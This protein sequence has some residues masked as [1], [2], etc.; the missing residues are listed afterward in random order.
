MIAEG[1]QA[2]RDGALALSPA[3]GVGED[4]G[5]S[6]AG[7]SSDDGAGL[8]EELA[9]REGSGREE[10][11]ALG[12]GDGGD[13]HYPGPLSPRTVWVL[14]VRVRRAPEMEPER[15][16]L[17]LLTSPKPLLEVVLL[18]VTAVT[19]AAG[20]AMALMRVSRSAGVTALSVS[21]LLEVLASSTTP[22]WVG[23]ATGS[24]PG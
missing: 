9:G 16:A 8:A 15:V 17:T 6:P 3:E 11:A 14:R 21:V 20:M 7:S 19:P 23:L 18:T 4:I 1:R 2:E 24:V 13:V 22:C 5:R 10:A 12:G